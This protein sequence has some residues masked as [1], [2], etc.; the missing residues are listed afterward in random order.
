MKHF[1]NIRGDTDVIIILD[2]LLY[3]YILIT[4]CLY[5]ERSNRLRR[6]GTKISQCMDFILPNQM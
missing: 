4:L 3:F 2:K 1:I 6:W 5:L